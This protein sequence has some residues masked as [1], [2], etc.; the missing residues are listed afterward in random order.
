[1]M[2]IQTEF[3]QEQMKEFGEQT[4]ESWRDCNEGDA[5]YDGKAVLTL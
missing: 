3:M 4:E 5:K 1:M 2:R